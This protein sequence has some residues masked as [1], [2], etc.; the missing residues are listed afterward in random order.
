MLAA[1]ICYASVHACKLL[2]DLYCSDILHQLLSPGSSQKDR[3]H[4][5][6]PQTPGCVS[7]QHK[8]QSQQIVCV[9]GKFVPNGNGAK[10]QQ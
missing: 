6:V 7:S 10:L 9:L 2:S 1:V 3:V 8:T 5:F 4:P